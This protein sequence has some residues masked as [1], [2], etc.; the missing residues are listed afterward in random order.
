MEASDLHSHCR[1]CL[2][3]AVA[4]VRQPQRSSLDRYANFCKLDLQKK[5]IE[6]MGSPAEKL[7]LRYSYAD[8]QTWDDGKRWELI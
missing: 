1:Y 3:D 7:E 8:Y 2:P 4:F 5:P 6:I